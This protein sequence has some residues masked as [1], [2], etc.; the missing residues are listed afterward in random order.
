M[1]RNGNKVKRLECLFMK[2]GKNLRSKVKTFMPLIICSLLLVLIPATIIARYDLKLATM[3]I[4]QNRMVTTLKRRVQIWAMQLKTKHGK[5]KENRPIEAI[6][7][8]DIF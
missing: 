8:R 1:H 6:E 3:I 5:R 7:A 2:K 4:F